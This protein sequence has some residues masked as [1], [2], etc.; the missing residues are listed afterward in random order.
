MDLDAP[1]LQVEFAELVGIT[2]PTV[3]GHL[4]SGTL[5][6]GGTYREWL[7]QY[8]DRLRLE[9]SGRAQSEARERRDAA[10]ARQ[11]EAKAALDEREL[12][13]QDGLLLDTDSVRRA[14]TDWILVAKNEFLAAVESMAL[15]IESTHG[16]TVD[17]ALLERDIEAALRAIGSY[18]FEPEATRRGGPPGLAT[19]A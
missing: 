8:T 1:A 3:A 16:I 15:A 13:R 12:L 14:M 9:A 2:Q 19:A 17:R 7:L 5:K 11:A 6:P 18:E 10:I 4:K